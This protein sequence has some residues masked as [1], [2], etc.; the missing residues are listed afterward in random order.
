MKNNNIK[1]E[2]SS[3]LQSLLTNEAYLVIPK[4]GDVVHGSVISTGRREVRVNINGVMT[5]V[6]RG[7]ELF[8]ESAGIVK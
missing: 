2:A 3:P 5:G 1:E 8:A 4:V 7:R 6:V